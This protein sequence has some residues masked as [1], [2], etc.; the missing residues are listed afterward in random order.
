MRRT[1]HARRFHRFAQLTVGAAA[2]ILLAVTWM[3]AP[4][5]ANTAPQADLDSELGE[6]AAACDE[7]SHRIGSLLDGGWLAGEFGPVV[8]FGCA[9]ERGANSLD[10]T[11][12]QF[13][14]L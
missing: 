8:R 9:V 5:P 1:T 11:C 7:S 2:A 4:F 10:Q 12:D 14:A 13:S 3:R 6:W